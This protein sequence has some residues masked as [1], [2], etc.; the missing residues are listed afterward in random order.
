MSLVS[1]YFYFQ[2]KV[3]W[4][5]ISG[6]ISST[7]YDSIFNFVERK[8][9]NEY[10]IFNLGLFSKSTHHQIVRF[11]RLIVQPAFLMT[12]LNILQALM[13]GEQGDY[14]GGVFLA[15]IVMANM[16]GYFTTLSKFTS[17][18]H[19][20]LYEEVVKMDQTPATEISNL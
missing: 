5:L 9:K 13:F 18:F 20:Y 12:T 15:G 1:Q 8:M 14:S 17:V 7:V 16:K 6:G 4:D 11:L 2:R 10:P 3:I 19:S